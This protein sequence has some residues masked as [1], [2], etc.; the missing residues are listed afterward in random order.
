[1]S[2]IHQ[3]AEIHSTAVVS[4]SAEIGAGTRI[5]PFCVI[6]SRVKIGERN[7]IHSHVVIDGIT[8]IGDDNTIY[9]FASVGAAPQDLKYHGEE[10]V[11]RIGHKNIIREYATLQPGTEGGGMQTVVGDGNL[12]MACSHVGHDAIV[13]NRNIFANAATLAGHVTVGSGS[14]IGG[15][16]GIHQFV[17][18]G[19]LTMIG[20]GAMVSKDIPPFCTA[21]GDRASLIGLNTIGMSRAGISEADSRLLKKLYRSIFLSAGTIQDTVTSAREQY[22][23]NERAAQFLDF[24]ANSERGVATARSRLRATAE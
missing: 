16:V 11:L 10:S 21:Q 18:V 14:V 6:G 5:G 3:S 2:M 13:G 7:M 12:F 19:D 1:M 23:S 24:I 8:T 4:E 20:A 15:L 22:A 17:H 9:Q